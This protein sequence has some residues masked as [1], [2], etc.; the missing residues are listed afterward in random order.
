MPDWMEQSMA[1]ARPELYFHNSAPRVVTDEDRVVQLFHRSLTQPPA[2]HQLPPDNAGFVGRQAE[3]SAAIAALNPVLYSN[4][5][6][7]VV[8]AI[9]GR[10]GVGKS[11]LAMHL[12]H[13][14]K[15]MLTDAQLYVNL[16][17]SESQP[18]APDGV[19][20][21]FLKAWGIEDHMMPSDLS[22]RSI[23][24]QSLMSDKRTV[25]VLDNAADVAQVRPLIPP[26]VMCAV[27]VTSREPLLELEAATVLKLDVLSEPEAVELLQ[28]LRGT[29]AAAD[30]A[31][32][33]LSAVS[34]CD[35][36]PLSIALFGSLLRQSH[37][38]LAV[39]VERLRTERQRFEQQRLSHPA[40][41][42][43]FAL[44]YNQLE[45]G[46]AY[47]LRCL[48]LLVE[49][50]VT[51]PL[52]AVLLESGLE[53]T[54]ETVKQLVTL[55]LLEPIGSQG[56][57]FAHDLIRLLARGQLA[58]AETAEARQMARLRVCHWYLETAEIMNLGLDPLTRF[59][60]AQTLGRR[61]RQSLAVVEQ[62]LFL[63]ALYWFETERSNL[64]A[65]IDWADQAE[66]WELV[67]LL[68]G[69]L[70][71]FFDIQSDWGDWERTHKLALTIAHRL[72]DRQKEAQLL[73]DL[74]NAS[75]R[76]GRWEKAK[77]QYEQSLE[78]FQELADANREA[79]TLTNLGVLYLQLNQ[80][81]PAVA[82]L[83]RA[84]TKLPADS[85]AQKQL[86]K[87]MQSIDKRLLPKPALLSDERNSRSFFQVLSGVIKKVIGEG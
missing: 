53:T 1:G 46:A 20:A 86:F 71:N 38:P 50:S 73:N 43:S 51:L 26:G 2:L 4:Q 15:R 58:V 12:A 22:A 28:L 80:S 87:W 10:A 69:S 65:A 82:L 34:L 8:L 52:A 54:R 60:L 55:R 74:G 41:R 16:K 75:M 78:I 76:Q 25:L 17:G 85:P 18:L 64:L 81:E 79:Y 14:I 7:S 19:L 11:A 9:A 63:R 37:L 33:S 68:V 49:P 42:A 62:S 32:E 77:E 45:P 24:F 23:L 84:L 21:G 3:I 57:R 39:G 70:V 35:R 31:D 56:Y 29:A 59:Q 13:Q 30:E 67:L 44:S 48:G 83:S 6:E 61:G 72:G 47:L 40:V 5:A 27:L 66:A 36:L